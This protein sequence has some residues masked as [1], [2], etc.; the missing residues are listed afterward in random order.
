M[1]DFIRPPKPV[2]KNKKRIPKE[3]FIIILII[4]CLG[5][6]FIAGYLYSR[7]P[8]T[9]IKGN[10]TESVL[11][12]AYD[13]L[14]NNWVN[15]SDKEV[16]LEK[17]S[18]EGMVSALG[19]QHTSYLS[20]KD[21]VEFNESVNG[22]YSGIGVTYSRVSN[23]A[24]VTT[25][26]ANSPA[27]EVGIQVGDIIH[28]AGSTDLS[29]K[30]E[31]D[32][33][34]LIRGASGTKVTLTIYRGSE[35]LTLEVTR[36]SIDGSI[37]YEIR[38]TNGNKFGY[39]DI[40]TFGSSTAQEVDVALKSFKDSGINE[41][42]IDLR[43]N[44]GGYLLAAINILDLF[45]DS[46]QVIYQ[47]QTKGKD[48]EITKA[49]SDE[50]YEFEKGFI[51]VDSN[52]AS[53]SELTAGALQQQLGYQIVG[54]QTFGKG[55]AQ[56]QA[57]LS[58]GSVLKYT[59]AK[60]MLPDG[61][62]IDGVGLTPDIKIDNSNLKDIELGEIETPLEV[63]NVSTSVKSMQL[64]LGIIGYHCDRQ[65]GYFSS[66]TGEMLQQFEAACGLPVDGKYDESDRLRLVAQV[67]IFINNSDNDTQYHELMK[68]I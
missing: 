9:I 5:I 23:G 42:V 51:L 34:N 28:M 24:I 65:D 58:D 4:V 19:D 63:D 39:I 64:M 33:R 6:G 11:D 57:T 1:D 47:M 49:G 68:L 67:R 38:E 66:Q 27:S 13:L 41:L 16:N 26:T 61:S 12:E 48:P 40:S 45:F 56:T 18:I 20:A 25:V 29:G 7:G 3:V 8:A 54:S 53:A 30:S 31:E 43:A 17:N 60:W 15:A 59:Y 37:F 52:T 62:S 44:G 14:K 55:T 21:A 36:N 10:D 46:D 2:E 32:I 35:T 50:K 22:T